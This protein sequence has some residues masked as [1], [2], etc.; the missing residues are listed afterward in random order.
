MVIEEKPIKS[1]KFVDNHLNNILVVD[2]ELAIRKTISKYLGKIGYNV[3]IAE[4]GM[5]AIEK[6]ERDSFDL[7]LTDLS[8]PNCD[9]RELLKTMASRFPEIPKIVLTGISSDEDILIALKTGAYDYLTKPIDD[10][11]VL[12]RAVERALEVKN[13]SDEKKRYVEQVNQINEVISMLN[14]GK[15]TD[16]VFKALNISLKEVIAFNCLKLMMVNPQNNTVATKL[17]ESDREVKMEI[18]ES[19]PLEGSFLMDVYEKKDVLIIND[20]KDF[21]STHQDSGTDTSLIDEGMGSSLILPLIIDDK[22]RGFLVFVAVEPDFFRESHITFLKSIVG[23]ISFS[24]Q[25]GELLAELEVHSKNLEY[26]VKARTDEVLKTQK[27]TVFAL[28]KLAEIRDPETG[29]HL[30]RIRNY[31]VLIAQILKYSGHENEITNQYIRDI[32][33]SSILHDIGKVGIP[34]TILLKPGPLT[35][36]EFEIMKTHTTIGYNALKSSSKDLGKNSFLN[37]AMDIVHFHHERWDG[38]GYPMGLREREIPLSAR[39]VAICDTYDALTSKRPYK[40]PF[41]HEKAVGIIKEDTF[42]FDP[43]LYKIFYENSTQF[44]KIRKQFQADN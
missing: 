5:I 20:L 14:R 17:V 34:D 4:D 41:S 30:E 33:D 25:R 19:F 8:M 40:E 32:Y 10:F 1:E 2:D 42:H 3:D 36:E 39:I 9:G 38:S 7:V 11:A 29:E 12:R 16:E 28:S 31:A 6:M 37:M 35:K 18:G 43:D 24:I 26:L 21:F 15:N 13:L 44:D 22:T 27:T 23:Q